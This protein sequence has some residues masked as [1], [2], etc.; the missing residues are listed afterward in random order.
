MNRFN[1]KRLEHG[2]WYG[3]WFNGKPWYKDTNNNG[4]WVGY[5]VRYYENGKIGYKQINI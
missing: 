3:K 1:K 2:Y 4:I 5:E